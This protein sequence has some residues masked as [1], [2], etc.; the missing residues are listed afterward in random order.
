M[1][2][3]THSAGYKLRYK[4]INMDM[5]ICHPKY[6]ALSWVP[7]IGFPNGS[8]QELLLSTTPQAKLPKTGSQH[9]AITSAGF[10]SSDPVVICTCLI[11]TKTIKSYKN[12]YNYV[13]RIFVGK[14]PIFYS[15]LLFF[16]VGEQCKTPVVA[17][18][19]WSTVNASSSASHLRFCR[20]QGQDAMWHGRLAGKSPENVGKCVV[21]CS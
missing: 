21:K 13:M 15:Y 20:A 12:V 6:R 14:R 2:R 18:L 10:S 5:P 3:L 1:L 8:N 16:F 9:T 4:H 19:C 17:H 11:W 7:P